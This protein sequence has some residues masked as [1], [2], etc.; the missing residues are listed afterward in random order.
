MAWIAEKLEWLVK[1]GAAAGAA[2]VATVAASGAAVFYIV[3]LLSF[4]ATI[5]LYRQFF[6]RPWKS[7]MWLYAAISLFIYT[8]TWFFPLMWALCYVLAASMRWCFRR[9]G[10]WWRRDGGD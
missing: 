4:C 2:A 8:A 3:Y 7:L 9:M 1:N 5:S 6:P 10:E